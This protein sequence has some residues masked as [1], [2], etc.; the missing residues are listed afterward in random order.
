MA[1]EE[2]QNTQNQD[3]EKKSEVDWEKRYKDEQHKIKDLSGQVEQLTSQ[4][5]QK[6]QA[7]EQF[8]P[9]IN[10]D[11]LQ[12]KDDTAPDPNEEEFVSRKELAAF[13]KRQEQQRRADALWT[14]FRTSNPDLADYEHLVKAYLVDK[15]DRRKTPEDRLKDAADSTRKLLDAERTRGV[16]LKVQQEKDKAAK[17]AEA[18]GLEGQKA[19]QNNSQGE[20]KQPETYEE[21]IARRQKAVAEGQGF[22]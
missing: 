3:S 12:G 20:V 18:G 21:Y 11:K 8:Y 16:E 22:T 19:S 4:V 13:E 1:K 5:T 15:T 17:E 9:Y 7:I 14:G 10:W 2:T 6:D